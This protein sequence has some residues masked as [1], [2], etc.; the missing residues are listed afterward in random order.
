MQECAKRS[1]NVLKAVHLL[2]RSDMAALVFL[3]LWNWLHLPS[4]LSTEPKGARVAASRASRPTPTSWATWKPSQESR[5]GSPTSFSIM[6]RGTW[7]CRRQQLSVC[8]FMVH[9]LN[10]AF[11]FILDL[12]RLDSKNLVDLRIYI[13]GCILGCKVHLRC[14]CALVPLFV[15]PVE[16][17]LRWMRGFSMSLW[18]LS[19]PQLILVSEPNI[20]DLTLTSGWTQVDLR[21]TSGW[22]QVLT[23][24]FSATC[25]TLACGLHVSFILCALLACSL[26]CLLACRSSW[27]P[28]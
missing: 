11:N 6:Q 22:P 13:G 24:S 25:H 4:F 19:C 26:A 23:E 7:F 15:I 10:F 14:F 17:S 8:R 2:R 20:G 16:Q 5:F 27:C 28:I 21:L 3:S 9:S 18:M 1:K 12:D